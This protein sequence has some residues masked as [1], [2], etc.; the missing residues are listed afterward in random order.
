MPREFRR[1]LMTTATTPPV[2]ITH[3]RPASQPAITDEV[4]RFEDFSLRKRTSVVRI[5]DGVGVTTEWR[6]RPR[7]EYICQ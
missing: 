5:H 2:K 6:S 4:L 7:T 3:G 1:S